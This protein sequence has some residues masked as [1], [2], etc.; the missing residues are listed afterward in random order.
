MLASERVVVQAPM[1]YAGSAKRIWRMTRL[2]MWL[3]IVAV[4]A[5]A[6]AWIV[7]TV[8]YVVF[9]ILLVPYR[10]IRRGGR[11]Q[12]RDEL[13]HREMMEAISRQGRE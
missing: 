2:T 1:S 7:V 5:I 6:V 8:W 12:K 13:R 9:G 4:V 11:K 3:S 10:L